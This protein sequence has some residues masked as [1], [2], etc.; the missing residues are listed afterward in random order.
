MNVAA[1]N[2]ADFADFR[3]PVGTLGGDAA[4][5][6]AALAGDIVLKLDRAGVVRDIAATG[7]EQATL[8]GFLGRHFDEIVAVESKP[9]IT[10]L[11]A[12]ANPAQWR[13]VNHP[14]GQGNLPVRYRVVPLPD[15]F[16]AIGRDVRSAA[17]LQQRLLQV[18]QS[19]ERDH[20]KLRQTETRWRLLFDG[21]SEP[22][23]VIDTASG[24]IA[25]INSAATRLIGSR[26]ERPAGQPLATQFALEDRD[27]VTAF[28]GA[29]AAGAE[30]AP[31]TVRLGRSARD[32]TLAATPFRKDGGAFC[33][34]RI[35]ANAD[36]RPAESVDRKLLDVVAAM[37]DA[38]VVADRNLVIA[39]ANP[40]MI[41]LAQAV[42]LEQLRGRPLGDVLG[43][44]GIDLDLIA[45][46]LREHGSVRNVATVVLGLA[47]GQ[48]EVEVSAT[49]IDDGGEQFG[50]AIRPVGRRLRDLPPADR[51]LPRSVEQLTEL[52]GRMPLKNIVRESTD[53][54]ERLC[55]EAALA[56]TSDNRASAAEI[57]GLSRQSLYSKLHRHGLGNLT[58][59]DED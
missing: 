26:F 34:L 49:R 35:A 45:G 13:Q 27:K 12:G 18:Q 6:L 8:R 54:I 16:L 24:R 38:F 29:V 41:D 21:G 28:L 51:D 50:F 4:T 40:A 53:L 3:E 10:E 57:L 14:L 15:G 31:V 47:G 9:K 44:P 58:G 23:M 56:F 59:E 55:I 30:V 19:L 17:V 37:P 1:G 46:Q 42:S 32:V 36:A 22:M 2:P 52:V 39:T 25:E 48:E 33:L 43:R 20:L 11:L 5:R 7:I